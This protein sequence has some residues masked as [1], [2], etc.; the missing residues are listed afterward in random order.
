MDPACIFWELLLQ[1]GGAFA[2]IIEEK[3]ISSHQGGSYEQ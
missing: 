2:T 3:E 1:N